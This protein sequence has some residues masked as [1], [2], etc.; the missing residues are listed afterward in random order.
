MSQESN[1]IKISDIGE[2][3][4]KNLLEGGGGRN[5]IGQIRRWQWN[6][7]TLGLPHNYQIILNTIVIGLKPEEQTSQ[8]M[9]EKRPYK[10]R[11]GVGGE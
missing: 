4:R 2:S 6:R 11:Q 5:K 1:F 7:C 10:R 8:V 3:L 9:V